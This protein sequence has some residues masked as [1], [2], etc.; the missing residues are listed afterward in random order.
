MHKKYEKTQD[1]LSKI[2]DEAGQF[3]VITTIDN[4]RKLKSIC[5][6]NRDN[7][8]DQLFN[9]PDATDR[10]LI[11][12]KESHDFILPIKKGVSIYPGDE[13]KLEKLD[14]DYDVLSYLGGGGFADVYKAKWKSRD[15]IVALKVPRELTSSGEKIFFK[16]FRNWEKLKHRNI[17]KLIEPRLGPIPHLVIEYVD[18]STLD[19]L[20]Q[21]PK[22]E[23]KDACRIAF[24]V[25][26]GL[27]CAHSKSIIHCDLKPKNILINNIGEAKITDFGIAKTKL[28]TSTGGVG[29]T[30]I[31]AAP[32]QL[33][34]NPDYGT[35]VYQLGLV[36]Y[37]MITGRNPYDIGSFGEIE[38]AII[39]EIPDAPSTY[40][41]D[42]R[43][44]DEI[45]MSCLAKESEKRP[46]IRALRDRLYE[47]M[48]KYHGESLH[49]TKDNKSYVRLAVTNAFYAI[50][51]N[52]TTECILCLKMAEKQVKNESFRKKIRNFLK[53]LENIQEEKADISSETVDETERLL[54]ETQ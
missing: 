24:D 6:N 38:K 26:A 37:Q 39:E 23:I 49:I 5:N 54:K 16:E 25:A 9:L 15:M 53:Q 20:L 42:A 46:T 27:E 34:G 28:A 48:K 8:N 30:L 12:V 3:K 32:E 45:I 33:T 52:D 13:N 22:I 47:Y 36:L 10:K 41:S 51:N 40:I 35:D 4:V 2:E 29:R 31:Y 19:K 7:C 21:S 17:V 44:L 50:K 14:R 11:T 18:G 43:P 1:Y